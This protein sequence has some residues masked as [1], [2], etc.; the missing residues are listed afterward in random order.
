MP[1]LSPDSDYRKVAEYLYMWTFFSEDLPDHAERLHSEFAADVGIDFESFYRE[2]IYFRA[3]VTDWVL[4]TAEQGDGRIR[5]VREDFNT[6]IT[7]MIRSQANPREF[8]G[9]V[10]AHMSAYEAAANTQH[11]LG[12]PWAAATVF[13]ELCGDHNPAKLVSAVM[14]MSIE[15]AHLMDIASNALRM[16]RLAQ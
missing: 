9:A 7:L 11:R 12:V 16:A 10:N 2:Y 6:L 4:D 3:F 5:K 1:P 8:G 14:V 13:C 15:F